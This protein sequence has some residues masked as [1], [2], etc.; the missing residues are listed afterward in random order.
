[1]HIKLYSDSWSVSPWFVWL[2]IMF[3]VHYE[4]V[5]FLQNKLKAWIITVFA[6]CGK[7]KQATQQKKY[8]SDKLSFSQ[9]AKR[10]QKK[11]N[12]NHG[13]CRVNFY[14]EATNWRGRQVHPLYEDTKNAT[15]P[16]KLNLQNDLW[17]MCFQ[18]QMKT[19]IWNNLNQEEMLLKASGV[20]T[21]PG[22]AM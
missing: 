1:M 11:L 7:S 14:L 8:F 16:K 13:G 12:A 17:V 10:D 19:C 2:P 18:L 15:Y 6:W 22:Y 5:K 4:K 20:P 21:S 9:I 3:L